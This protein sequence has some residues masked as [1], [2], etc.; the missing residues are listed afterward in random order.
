LNDTIEDWI[1]GLA[2][3]VAL[4]DKAMKFSAQD[5]VYVIP[6][7]LL[8]LWFWPTS[9]R[10]LNQRVATASF[11]AS[12]TS[13]LAAAVLGHIFYEARPFVSDGS[14][15]LLINHS[16][17]NGFPSEHAILAFSVAGSVVWWRPLLGG[18]G[19]VLAALLGVARI[20][21]GVH[22]PLDIL[23]SAA[24]GLMA[25][26]LLAWLVPQL[27]EPQRW[28]SRFLPSFFLASP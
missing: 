21:V 2:G 1:N 23:V 10:A 17:D 24:V 12:L 28:F 8:A 19:L 16:P 15:R 26:A 4:L 7:L 9:E 27:R 13:L 14:A 22:W 18:I 3:H 25:G 20:Y 11:I 6:L 5:I